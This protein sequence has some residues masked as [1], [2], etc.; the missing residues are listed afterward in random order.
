MRRLQAN[1]S[2]MAAM[3]DRKP[4][5]KVPP[6][7][8]FLSAPPLNLTLRPRAQPSSAEGTDTKVD[9]STDREQR[10]KSIKELYARLQAVFPGFDP[11]KEPPYRMPAAGKAGNPLGQGSPAPSKAP[12]LPNAPMPSA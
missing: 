1:L 3:A 5:A 4:D 7:P 8:A 10:D 9:P 11:K 2:F 12:Q 6:C